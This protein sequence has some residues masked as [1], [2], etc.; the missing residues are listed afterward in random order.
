[1]VLQKP[2]RLPTALFHSFASS[3]AAP[4]LCRKS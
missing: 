1:V 4:V 3:N 2:Q